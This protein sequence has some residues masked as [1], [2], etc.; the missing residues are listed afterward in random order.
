MVCIA[1][2][3]ND[4][5]LGMSEDQVQLLHRKLAEIH[6]AIKMAQW[7]STVIMGIVTGIFLLLNYLHGNKSDIKELSGKLDEL[8]ARIEH[9]EGLEKKP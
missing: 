2:P 8:K 9:V 3:G 4:N 1:M 6:G 5:F 7:I